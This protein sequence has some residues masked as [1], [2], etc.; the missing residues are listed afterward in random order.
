MKIDDRPSLSDKKRRELFLM[1]KGVCHLCGL[2]IDG[3]RERW[4]VEHV[5]PRSMLG[6]LADTDD[7]MKPAHVGCHKIKTAED[8][9]NLARAVR[10]EDRHK[11]V[12]RSKTPMPFGRNSPLKKRMDGSVVR[13]DK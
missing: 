8:K 6:K 4:E 13:R 2:K 9:G 1:H 11:G 3:T 12:H 5:I 7:N 10:R